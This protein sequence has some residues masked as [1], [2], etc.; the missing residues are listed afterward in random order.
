MRVTSSP[1]LAGGAQEVARPWWRSL[2][3]WLLGALAAQYTVYQLLTG[4]QY[5]DGPRNMQWGMYLVENPGFAV[6]AP[7]AYDRINGFPPTPRSLA[8][9]GRYT[10]DGGPI[11]P[12][13]GPAYLLVYGVV[14]RLT[15]SYVA[16]HL[17]VP[18]AA[19]GAVLVTYAFGVRL[20]GRDVGLLAAALLALFPNFRDTATVALVEPISALLIT[21]ALWAFLE[22]RSAVAALL[23]SL[24][25]L[26]K[27]DMIA[28]YLGTAVCTAALARGARQLRGMRHL[29]IAVG[30]PLLVGLG[31]AGLIYGYFGRPT[32]L[33]GRPSLEMFAL[34]MPMMLDQLF[35]MRFQSTLPVVAVMLGAAALALRRG[36]SAHPAVYTLLAVWVA[37]GMLTSC[38]FA[39]M[40]DVSNNP[41]IF[42]PAL[43]ALFVLVADGL[44]RLRPTWRAA[45]AGLLI[46]FFLVVNGAGVLY[47]MVQ[48][49]AVSATMPVWQV[50][51]DEPRGFVLTEHYWLA[52][53]YARQPATWFE[54]DPVFE[55]NIMDDLANFRR[56]LGEHPI[57][58]VVLPRED[59]GMQRLRADSL[60]RLYERLPIGRDLGWRTSPTASAEVRAYLEATFPRREVG[61]YVIYFVRE[62]ER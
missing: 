31:W 20:V 60:A 26:G 5:F 29:A 47:Q 37:L 32:T 19:A 22:R 38:V 50:L 43:P 55:R 14:W 24:A 2:R 58:Y 56:Y 40:P 17:V 6:G 23:A 39:A 18:L 44:L 27:I 51:R 16:L 46:V 45:A 57:R 11:S 34:L 21:G 53:L 28:I 9:V 15:G 4:V 62:G 36:W 10:T 42:I 12:W 30:I 1:V 8:P 41:R 54:G 52:A 3:R 25:M 33:S 7:N 13:W 59:D 49:R 48:A 61:E 35:M